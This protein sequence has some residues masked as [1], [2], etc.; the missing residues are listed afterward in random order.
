MGSA[1]TCSRGIVALPCCDWSCDPWLKPHASHHQ[2]QTSNT[3]SHLTVSSL[4]SVDRLS[5]PYDA[6]VDKTTDAT[7]LGLRIVCAN[8]V[9][10][11]L[12]SRNHR[13]A[14]SRFSSF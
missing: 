11:V 14:C 5:L 6:G 10:R 8:I 3:T 13:P 9:R 1:K 12:Q 4:D 7:P 2:P